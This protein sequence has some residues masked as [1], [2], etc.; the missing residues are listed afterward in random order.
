MSGSTGSR[1]AARVLSMGCSSGTGAT[2]LPGRARRPRAPRGL[3]VGT[4]GHPLGVTVR[5]RRAP[6]PVLRA[7]V[8]TWVAYR[9]RHVPVSYTHLR[10]HETV[11]DLVC[12][13][14]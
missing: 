3:Q 9:R 7:A 13:L 4:V 8:Y 10:A 5:V 2:S 12:R 6:P 1:A 14:L 11:L